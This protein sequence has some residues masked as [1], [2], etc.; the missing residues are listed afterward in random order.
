MRLTDADDMEIT[1]VEPRALWPLRH[2]VLRPHQ[3]LD[4]MHYRGDDLPGTI[5]LAAF[6]TQAGPADEQPI[7]I[8]S[9]YITPKPG[10]GRPTDYRLRGM[11]VAPAWQGRGVGSALIR[12]CLTEVARLGGTR[13]WCN[14][15][16]TAK[17]FYTAMGFDFHGD[18][19]DIVDIGPHYLM[20]IEVK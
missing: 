18:Q 1:P 14:A 10:D 11:A 13:V 4:E 17:G 6:D 7:A 5:H 8:V 9:L 16:D 2:S 20:S 15:R 3:R 12:A 19:F